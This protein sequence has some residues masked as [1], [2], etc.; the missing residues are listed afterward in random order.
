M[1]NLQ[2]KILQT[3]TKHGI[4]ARAYWVKPPEVQPQKHTQ[5]SVRAS[6]RMEVR[7][8][9]L[10]SKIAN[11]AISEGIK[12]IEKVHTV[13]HDLFK[14]PIHVTGSLGKGHGSDAAGGYYPSGRWG[15]SSNSTIDVNK[16]T[17]WPAA[18]LVHEYGHFL[19]HHLWGSVTEH[20]TFSRS[21]GTARKNPDL[22]P[23]MMAIYRSKAGR[24]LQNAY[25]QVEKEHLAT[26]KYF[27]NPS[28]M[29]A[30]AYTQWIALR[31]GNQKLR[32][33]VSQMSSEWREFGLHTQ[34][35]K[36]DFRLIAKE[37]DRLF[38]RRGLINRGIR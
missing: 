21:M 20:S 23:L 34:W 29:F 19:D 38:T 24:Q 31:S 6:E 18:T 1:N 7:Y 37:F 35:E 33:E 4:V 32:S 10:H 28:E 27:L 15:W 11:Q 13:P 16:H 9:I 22:K 8:G 30:R 2:R 25:S 17:A 12:S 5:T 36:Q 26:V 14:I 3:H